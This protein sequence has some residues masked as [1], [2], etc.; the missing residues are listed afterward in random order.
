MT[1]IL[2]RQPHDAHPHGAA[3]HADSGGLRYLDDDTVRDACGVFGVWGHPDA[4]HVT[5]CGLYA[6]Q[7]RGQESA[8]IVASDGRTVVFHK[9]MG[10]VSEVFDDERVATL[11]GHISI[12]HV[13]YSTSGSSRLVNAQP[14]V[15]RYRGGTLALA[16]NGNLVNAVRLRTRLEDEGS[17]FQTTVDTEVIAHLVARSRRTTLEESLTEAFATI[18]G[19]YAVVAMNEKT[20]F[21]ARDPN[22]FRPLAVGRFPDGGWV[23]AS[24]TCAFD[25]LGAEFVREVQPGEMVAIDKG[26]LRSVRA[27]PAGKPALCVFEY[28]Y[29][30]RP[31][32]NIEGRNVHTVR[33]DLGRRLALDYPVEADIVTGVP[34]SSLSA[35]SG[36]A[37][38]AGIPYELGL[39]K[40]RYIGRTFIQPTKSARSFGVQVKLNPLRK[41]LEGRRVV[42]VDDSIVR[43]TTSKRIVNLLREAGATEVHMRIASPPYRFPC[44]Y[45][46]DTSA[47]GD[48]IAVGREIEDIRQAIGADSLAYLSTQALHETVTGFPHWP[49][50]ER[51]CMACFTGHYP[52]VVE[53]A[54]GKFELEEVPA[55]TA[56]SEST[57]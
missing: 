32:S 41:V 26:D 55:E 36:Y 46:I 42:L 27:V 20:L 4:A 52:V 40:N 37:E 57:V 10:L 3:E 21:A 35:A 5:Y 50:A 7:H 12:G 25:S 6:L 2:G 16:H 51:C 38:Q 14:V 45:G 30:A 33:K 8:G 54:G 56:A 22:G 13:R 34:D 23:V 53:D 19:G 48:L 17:I 43:G 9:G 15:V 24:E 49:V 44:Y 29:L 18:K 31:D 28:I 11:P 39:V 1:R 47:T